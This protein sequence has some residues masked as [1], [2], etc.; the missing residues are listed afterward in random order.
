[1]DIE[2]LLLLQKLRELTNDILTPFMEL[3]SLFAVSYLVFI[4]VLVYWI[5]DKKKGLFPLAS[6]YF[7]I[8]INAVVKLTACIYRPWIRD[9]RVLPAGDSIRTAT[10]YSF[11]SGHTATA[12]PICGGL[13]KVFSDSKKWISRIC[14]ILLLITA[15]SRNYLGV[16]TPQ[17]VLF[18]LAESFL[19]ICAMDRIFRYIENNPEKERKASV[20]SF[21]RRTPSGSC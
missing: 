7:V 15:F 19:G 3:I 6:F 20:A 18:A 9:V 8:G 17:D 10:G 11:P 5:F 2:Y 12:G 14:M 4:P 21:C 16:H 13:S 1:M